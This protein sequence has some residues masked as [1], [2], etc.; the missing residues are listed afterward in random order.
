M[1]HERG[2]ML[3][4]VIFSLAIMGVLVLV[5]VGTGDDDRTGSR[6][7]YEGTRSFYAAETGLAYILTNWKANGYEA[8][9]TNV[10][11][12]TGVAWTPLAG[13]GSYHAVLQKVD[14]RSEERRVGKECRSR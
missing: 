10:G 2:F 6:Y 12:T 5:M 3:P 4:M 14:V 8:T 11:D 9:M 1:R 13:V 7:D